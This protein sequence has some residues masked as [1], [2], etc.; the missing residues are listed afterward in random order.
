MLHTIAARYH[1]FAPVFLRYALAIVFIL[2]G[3]HKLSNPG[4]TT[5]EVQLLLDFDIAD[6]A[7]LNYYLGLSEMAIALALLVGFKVRF[8]ALLA[9]LTVTLFFSS[10]LV[11]FGLSINPDLYRDVG[12]AGASLALFLLG[13]GPVSVDHF[14]L[15]EEIEEAPQ[16][17]AEEKPSE[18]EKN[19]TKTESTKEK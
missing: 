7:A 11:K 19:S 6:A 8:F 2:F 5:S 15:H 13:P 17:K 3:Y 10:Y 14:V 12:L 9:T 4:Q 18:S 16:E 1:R